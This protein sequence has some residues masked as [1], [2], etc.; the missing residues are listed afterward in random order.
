M[1]LSLSLSQSSTYR[2]LS[3][4]EP[5]GATQDSPG[6]EPTPLYTSRW[7]I[8]LNA[9]WSAPPAAALWLSAEPSE[10]ADVPLELSVEKRAKGAALPPHSKSLC[11]LNL[12][13]R[14]TRPTCV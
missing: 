3:C 5:Q 13:P 10:R 7:C 9:I 1:A 2:R 14:Y 4:L 8:I 6:R 11:W 12:I